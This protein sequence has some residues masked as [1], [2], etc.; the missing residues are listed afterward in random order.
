MANAQQRASEHSC[1]G[2]LSYIT[3]LRLAL[4]DKVHVFLEESISRIT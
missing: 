2:M 4:S 3:T 1:S